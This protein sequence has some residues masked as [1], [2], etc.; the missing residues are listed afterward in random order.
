MPVRDPRRPVRPQQDAQA[1][2]PQNPRPQNAR[3]AAAGA[4]GARRDPDRTQQF[5]AGG[6]PASDRPRRPGPDDTQRL[7]V[8]GR[9]VRSGGRGSSGPPPQRP[10][11][12]GGPPGDGDGT[13]APHRRRRWLKWV[14]VPLL[15]VAV[16][17]G[18]LVWAANSAWNNVT[19]VD[20]L[21]TSERPAAGKGHNYVLVGSD[22]RA[23]LTSE[24]AKRLGTGGSGIEGQR[25]DSIM[26]LHLPD[27]GSPTLVSLPRDSW[28]E[29]PGHRKNKINASY[30]LGG[31]KLLIETVEKAT[32]LRIDGYMEIGF[33]GFANVVDAVGGVRMCLDK[34][35]KDDKAHID[36]PAGCQNLDGKNA[37]GYVRARY[38]D[39][40]GDLGR[41]K[42]QRE[43]LSA[44]MSKVSSP[45]NLLVPWNLKGVGESGAQGLAVDKDMGPITALKVAWALKN[46]T[47]GGQSVQ[48]PVSNAAYPTYAGEAV[49]WDDTK[50]TALFDALRSDQSPNVQP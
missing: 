41:V 29:V 38:S 46:V 19:K 39:P 49:L 6:A 20:A 28:V 45:S 3:A 26:V 35:M 15:I 23:G 43:F 31:P 16:W 32:N 22:S 42:R 11:Y 9:P 4:Q 25:T 40:L 50:A 5:Q 13:P 24:E 34:P 33:G 10:G 27:S 2:Y 7:P 12:G 18:A 17:L 30:S 1:S 44:L 21:P 48:V 36:L 14:L 8:G 47:S 37:L